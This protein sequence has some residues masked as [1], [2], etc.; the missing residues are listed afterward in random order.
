MPYNVYQSDD[1]RRRH[2]IASRMKGGRRISVRRSPINEAPRLLRNAI[3]KTTTHKTLSR[4]LIVEIQ[5][6][7]GFY[8]HH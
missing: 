6:A 2:T 8:N 3:P 4:I 7:F 1:D 5:C